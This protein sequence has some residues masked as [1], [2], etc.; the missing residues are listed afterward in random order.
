MLGQCQG[1]R[2]RRFRSRGS[3]SSGLG[4]LEEGVSFGYNSHELSWCTPPA[5]GAP[6]VLGLLA[7]N[8]VE[9][10]LGHCESVF[11]GVGSLLVRGSEVMRGRACLC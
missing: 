8:V 6:A 1:I 7:W 4:D 2:S 3:C 10:D 5:V 9:D 11:E